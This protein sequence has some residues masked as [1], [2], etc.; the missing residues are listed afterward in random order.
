MEGHNG[1]LPPPHVWEPGE[2]PYLGGEIKTRPSTLPE[3]WDK[4]EQRIETR[5]QRYR[6][7]EQ[8]ILGDPATQKAGTAAG[9][10]AGVEAY[11]RQLSPL[12]GAWDSAK[13]QI[14]EKVHY[15]TEHY[16][17]KAEDF[18]AVTLASR[19]YE[20]ARGKTL[21]TGEVYQLD[22]DSYA[23][24]YDFNVKTVMRTESQSQ[25][26]Y[27]GKLAQYWLAPGGRGPAAPED[28]VGGAGDTA[29]GGQH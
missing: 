16:L 14:L 22:A 6:P 1:M 8:T 7:S 26:R 15:S 4:L 5:A 19:G 18:G 12:V 21:K 27:E 9:L 11:F 23:F 17:S 28:L 3:D 13:K 29:R 2:T 24:P 10:L 20:F 25:A